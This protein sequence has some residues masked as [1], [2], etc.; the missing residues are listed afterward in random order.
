MWVPANL[1]I[2]RNHRPVLRQQRDGSMAE[3]VHID[4]PRANNHCRDQRGAQDDG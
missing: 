1:E 3:P 4:D 2:R